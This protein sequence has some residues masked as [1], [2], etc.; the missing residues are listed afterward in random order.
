MPPKNADDG[1]SID[2]HG[3]RPEAAE[4]RLG[5]EL[6]AA[7]VRG[8]REILVITGRGFGNRA[9]EPILRRRLEAWLRGQHGKRLGVAAVTV[10]SRGGALRVRLANATGS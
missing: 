2:L 7:R 9:Q 3:L 4:R 5:Q 1:P 10:E 8:T 6:H